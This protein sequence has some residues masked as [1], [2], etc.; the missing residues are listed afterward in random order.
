MADKTKTPNAPRKRLPKAQRT[1]VRR[2]KQA[3]RKP[4]G[5]PS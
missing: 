5:V 2:Q 4:G 3:A 1:F